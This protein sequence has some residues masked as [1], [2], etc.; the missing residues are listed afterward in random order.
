LNNTGVEYLML[1]R[2]IIVLLSGTVIAPAVMAQDQ[3]LSASMNVHVF[4]REGQDEVQQ[5]MDEAECYSWGVERTGND[6]FDLSKQAAEQA[7]AAEQ[8][9]AQAQ[10]AGQGSTGRAAA[11]GAVAGGLIGGVFGS[12]SRSGW[13]GAAAGAATGAVIGNSR[14]RRGQ[15]EA[16][17]QVAQQSAQD[18]A[19][20]QAQM[21]DFKTAFT[22]CLEAKDYIAKF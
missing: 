5:S 2:L 3:G 19:I 17:Q 13:K 16:S 22:T 1:R 12:S 15:A 6:P 11:G 20:L 10:S 7:A 4:P 8:A 9:M 18:Q 21:E 14:K